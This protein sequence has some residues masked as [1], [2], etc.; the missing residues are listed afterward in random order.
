M[1]IIDLETNELYIVNIFDKLWYLSLLGFTW[2]SLYKVYL[3]K[4]VVVKQTSNKSIGA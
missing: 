3:L 2:F 1:Y 4:N